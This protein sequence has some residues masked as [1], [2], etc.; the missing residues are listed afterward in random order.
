MNAV[1]NVITGGGLLA[2]SL[3]CAYMVTQGDSGLT[4]GDYILF[5]T[6]MSQLTSPFCSIQYMYR[7]ANS[8]N[9]PLIYYTNVKARGNFASVFII[10][11]DKDER[12]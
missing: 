1:E 2:G 12:H 3:L 5:A 7:C 10:K 6:Y 4:V 9:L 11:Y 8:A